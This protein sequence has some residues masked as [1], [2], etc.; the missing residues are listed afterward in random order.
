MMTNKTKEQLEQ[1]RA[2]RKAEP[3]LTIKQIAARTKIAEWKVVRL[4]AE[5]SHGKRRRRTVKKPTVVGM[6]TP[7]MVSIQVPQEALRSVVTEI[8]LAQLQGAR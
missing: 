8:V 4:S 1:V 6:S 5:L 3:E 7:K 2:L